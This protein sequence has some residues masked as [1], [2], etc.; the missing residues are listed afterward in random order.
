[1]V[2]FR[3]VGIYRVSSVDKEPKVTTQKN[4]TYKYTSIITWLKPS[5]REIV[6]GLSQRGHF[7]QFINVKRKVTYV[8]LINGFQTNDPPCS[9]N[10]DHGPIRC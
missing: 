7:R 6:H 1:M 10:R 3:N 2:S 8:S 5:K 9:L 4:I